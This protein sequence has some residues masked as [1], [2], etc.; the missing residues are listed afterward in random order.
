MAASAAQEWKPSQR[1]S[2]SKRATFSSRALPQ[3]HDDPFDRALVAQALTVTGLG[4]VVV[5]GD[6]PLAAYGVQFIET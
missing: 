2:T 6:R 4:L 5:T 3:H 1:P